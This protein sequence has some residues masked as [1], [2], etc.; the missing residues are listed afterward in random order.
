MGEGSLVVISNLIQA[1]L[2]E[3]LERK[4]YELRQEFE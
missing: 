2:C 4:Y 3:V 1:A